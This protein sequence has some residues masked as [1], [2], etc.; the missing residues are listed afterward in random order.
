M[1][2]AMKGDFL[3][4]AEAA[5]EVEEVCAATQENVLAVVEQ[6]AGGFGVFERAGAAAEGV[7]GFQQGDAD[8]SQRRF[9]DADGTGDAGEAAAD[10]DDM[11]AIT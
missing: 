8:L 6:F 3:F 1:H 5:I 10:D 7:T 11:F 2:A 9:G 4:H